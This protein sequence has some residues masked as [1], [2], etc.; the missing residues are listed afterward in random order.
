MLE[1]L[2]E[3]PLAPHAPEVA[4][5]SAAALGSPALESPA[6]A[7]PSPG[8]FGRTR[9]RDGRLGKVLA[10]RRPFIFA[11]LFLAALVVSFCDRTHATGWIAVGASLVLAAAWGVRVWATGYRTWVRGSGGVRHLMSAG[12]YAHVRHPLYVANGVAG[13][14]A[15]VLLGRFEVLALYVPLYA[16]VTA[17]IVAREEEAL[18]ERYGPE[19]AAYSALV[20][21][22]VPLPGRSVARAE[23]AGDFSWLPVASGLELWKLAGLAGAVTG[24][25]LWLGV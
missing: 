14:A 11:P 20:P 9:P 17:A 13:A 7:P 23:R 1:T 15:L 21:R 8:F 25:F 3:A 12:P 2:P 4:R 6:V 10:R 18:D 5:V 22:F 19:H 24:Y 16:F